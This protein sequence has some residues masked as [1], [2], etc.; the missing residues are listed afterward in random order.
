MSW[1]SRPPAGSRR[2][3]GC[4]RSSPRP[5]WPTPAARRPTCRRSSTP[6]RAASAR[7]L[8]LGVLLRES[9]PGP[10][11]LRRDELKP[12][13]ELDRVLKDGVFYAATRLYGITFKERKDLPVYEP[14]CASTRCSTRT[15]RRSRCSSPTLCAPQ[16]ARRRL[17]ECLRAADRPD[18]HKARG[19]QPPERPEAARRPADAADAR[20]GEHA[21]PRVR[22]RAAR[23]V[24]RREVSA[25]RRHQRAARLRRV[26]LAGQRDV[27]HLARGAEAITRST[28][29]PARRSRRRCSTR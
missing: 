25:I 18:R 16:Q 26:P 10:L 19:G 13:F 14:T 3:T 29:R 1:K 17:D 23:H 28:T 7:R 9:P 6:R 27:G 20:R 12:Y 21:L 4:S 15:A 2:S 8:G 5:P 22:P 24:L 11:R